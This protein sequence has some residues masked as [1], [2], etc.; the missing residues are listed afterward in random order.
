VSQDAT[1]PGL[2]DLKKDPQAAQLLK[3]P[4]ALKHILA[5]PETKRLMELL[6]QQAGGGLQSAAQAA[7]KGKPEAL[8]GL[9][10]QVMRTSQGASAVE[11]LQ[12][13]APG[14]K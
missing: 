6:Q 12:K 7:A 2:E 8:M 9:I 5:A 3:D 10:N 4:S 1:Q 14:V 13:K 11:S